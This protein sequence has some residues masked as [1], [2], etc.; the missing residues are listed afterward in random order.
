MDSEYMDIKHWPKFKECEISHTGNSP[1]FCFNMLFTQVI[2]DMDGPLD[3]L[4]GEVVD[5]E[6]TV[7]KGY[8]YSLS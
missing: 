1:Y 8:W 4:K 6:K 3:F 2:L 7:W 5:V